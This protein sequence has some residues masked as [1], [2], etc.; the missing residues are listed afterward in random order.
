MSNQRRTST[1]LHRLSTASTSLL[2]F[3]CLRLGALSCWA[4]QTERRVTA[5]GGLSLAA[6]LGFATVLGILG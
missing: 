4:S 6:L 5:L 3:A 2:L 1:L